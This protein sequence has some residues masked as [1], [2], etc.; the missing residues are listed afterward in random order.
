MQE[1]IQN[2]INELN[3]AIVDNIASAEMKAKEAQDRYDH[4]I[5]SLT[6]LVSGGGTDVAEIVTKASA[7]DNVEPKCEARSVSNI[8]DDELITHL[9]AEWM[10]V[11]QIRK[12]LLEHNITGA[13][14]TVLKR[15]VRLTKQQPRKV[16]YA[17]GPHRWRLKQPLRDS[18]KLVAAPDCREGESMLPAG[19][20][21]DVCARLALAPPP[22]EVF[23]PDLV[24]ADCFTA[25]REMADA[26]VDL[27]L[28]DPPYSTTG[29]EI[30]DPVDLAALWAEYR[31]IIKPTGSIVL[32]GSQPF[33][34]RVV[35]EAPDLFKYDLVWVKNRP[36]QSLQSH[37]RPLKQHEDIMVFTLGSTAHKKR[38]SRRYTYHP[39][40][41]ISAG[42]KRVSK[43][44]RSDYLRDVEHNAG[45]SYEAT[46]R[47]PRSMIYC[48]KDRK[49]QHPF[50][51]PVDL[52]EYLIRTYSNEGDVVLDSFAGSGSTCLAAMRS[53]RRSIGI[54]LSDEYYRIA[55]RRVS[56]AATS[57]PK[58][59]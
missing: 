24:K 54:E 35:C 31:R 23:A 6:C 37:S 19:A 34:S 29:L 38:T 48:P 41:Q 5:R 32:F 56:E 16:K 7:N 14:T 2:I 1:R 27:I 21:T 26:S 30:D 13:F 45:R 15:L 52:L 33:S 42:V 28:T 39:L 50:Q 17:E 22:T 43:G 9:R 44:K 36:T 59:A 12:A 58:A 25:M 4:L 10:T 51:K 3:E 53:G 55:E 18:T 57:L 49:H 40:G 11:E 8:S 46:T 20:I 47:N